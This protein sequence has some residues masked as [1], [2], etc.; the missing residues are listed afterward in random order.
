MRRELRLR[1]RQDFAAVHR[2]GRSWPGALLVLRVLPNGLDV[3]R[4]GFSISK[5]V[6][7][8]VIRN[9]IRR[10]LREAVRALSPSPGFDLVVIARSPAAGADFGT[11]ASAIERLLKR[12]GLLEAPRTTPPDARAARGEDV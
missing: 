10:R 9:R 7:N 1:R 4:T 8:A 3:S 5:R 6:G 11:L 12:A 2:A